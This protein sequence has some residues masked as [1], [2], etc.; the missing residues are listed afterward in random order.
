M[1]WRIAERIRFEPADPSA[2]SGLPSRSTTVGA[3][4]LGTRAPGS[5]R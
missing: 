2:I 4:M 3:I 5:W 1:V